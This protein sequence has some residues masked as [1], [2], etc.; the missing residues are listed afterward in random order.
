MFYSFLVHQ[1]QSQYFAREFDLGTLRDEN[2]GVF[3]DSIHF[4]YSVRGSLD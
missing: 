4:F 1:L 3:R 2:V